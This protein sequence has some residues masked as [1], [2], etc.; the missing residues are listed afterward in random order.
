M[1]LL[2]AAALAVTLS[3]S[4]TA[5]SGTFSQGSSSGQ[6]IS[7]TPP[8][9][10]SQPPTAHRHTSVSTLPVS[11][12]TARRGATLR[13]PN[14]AWVYGISLG[15]RADNPCYLSLWWARLVDGDIHLGLSEFQ[16]CNRGGPT[17]ISLTSVGM[18]TVPSWDEYL[19]DLGGIPTVDGLGQARYVYPLALISTPG[20]A[21]LHPVETYQ[22]IGAM[23]NGGTP[24][25]PIF[26]RGDDLTALK[27]L[28]VCHNDNNQEMK[29]LS[30]RGV[31]VDLQRRPNARTRPIRRSNGQWDTDGAYRPN[32]DDRQPV[33]ACPNQQVIV[34]T[35]IRFDPG[36]NAKIKG[37]APIC[38]ALTAAS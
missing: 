31:T 32:C 25:Y 16:R 11:G 8:A 14:G 12:S 19:A 1:R 13:A 17:N 26:H 33:R 38:A 30:V 34:G 2:L 7:N 3:A 9:A 6:R 5:Q 18:N 4:A 36:T 37:L 20:F 24:R 15:E 23:F 21:V 29:G 35:T 28:Q 27:S 10:L 22:N